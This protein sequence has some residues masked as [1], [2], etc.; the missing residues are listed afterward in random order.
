MRSLTSRVQ[1]AFSPAAFSGQTASAVR[2][3]E[4]HRVESHPSWITVDFAQVG[5]A[6]VS[7]QIARLPGPVTGAD[8]YLEVSFTAAAGSVAPGADTGEIQMRVNK[9]DW[10]NYDET[11]D[12][13]WQQTGS[14]VSTTTLSDSTLTGNTAKYYGGGITNF[15]T[16]TVS[17]CTLSSNSATNVGGGIANIGRMTVNDI[18]LSLN[19]TTYYGGGIA[20][21]GTLMVNEGTLILNS[22]VYYGG[23][24]ANFGIATVNDSTLSGNSA[25]I[26]GGIQNFYSLTLSDT[27]FEDNTPNNIFGGYIDGGGNTFS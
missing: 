26:G 20:N 13:S 7:G 8:R 24:I 2:T 12:Y 10:T 5:N 4:A 27:T 11:N 6:N 15:G 21:F 22:A 18:T 3:P 25:T 19:T 1:I 23:G 16:M 14:Y 9:T 17:N